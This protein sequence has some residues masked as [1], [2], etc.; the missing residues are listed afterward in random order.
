MEENLRGFMA[1]KNT[2]ETDRKINET[3]Q[4]EPSE[5]VSPK[6]AVPNLVKTPSIL[7][8]MNVV[9]IE[10]AMELSSQTRH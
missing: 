5:R 10:I 1:R 2:E 9:D 6:K 3:F 7:E 4:S 8:N